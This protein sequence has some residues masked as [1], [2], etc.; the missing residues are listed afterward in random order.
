[1]KIG[2]KLFKCAA[3]GLMEGNIWFKKSDSHKNIWFNSSNRERKL[4]DYVQVRRK[5][6][7]RF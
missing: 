2:I 3:S 7:S 5:G 1:M 6:M 4:L